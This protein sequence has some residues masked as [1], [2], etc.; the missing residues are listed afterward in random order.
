MKSKNLLFIIRI[1]SVYCYFYAMKIANMEW[2][3]LHLF[4][5]NDFYVKAN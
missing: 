3:F 1:C 4:G 2:I 5:Y